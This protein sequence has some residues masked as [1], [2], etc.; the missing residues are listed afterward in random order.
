MEQAKKGLDVTLLLVTVTL[1]L[2]GLL[3]IYSSSSF[4]AIRSKDNSLFYIVNQLRPLF[5]GG[6]LALILSKINYK[7]WG[8]LSPVFLLFALFLLFYVVYFSKPINDVQRW[9]KIGGVSIQPSEFAKIAIILWLSYYLTRYREKIKRLC[10]LLPVVL[11]SSAVIVLLI[12]EPS[13]GVAFTI[14]LSVLILMFVGE[15][16]MKYIIIFTGLVGIMLL[17]S[18]SKTP[19]AKTRF[20]NY[21]SGEVY[22]VTQSM[23]AIGSGGI[24]GVG[25]GQGKEKLFFLPYPHTD[26]IFASFAEEIGLVGSILILGLFSIFFLRGIR[27]SAHAPTK[28]GSLLAF[29]LSLNIFLSALLHI[30]VASGLIPTTGIPLP[31]ISYGGSSLVVNLVSVGILLNISKQGKVLNS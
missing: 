2:L 7:I 18:M 25:L 30:G 17:L 23:Q 22:Q 29:G 12:L 21:L 14:C 10:W 20:D 6:L 26:F 16:K 13:F 11:V 4:H 27:I 1:L 9:I 3:A 31:F 15:V 28:F 24:F 8:K 5:I 19:Y